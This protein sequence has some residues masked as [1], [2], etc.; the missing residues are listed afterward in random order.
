MVVPKT[1]SKC[2][3]ATIVKNSTIKKD[4]FYGQLS[5]VWLVVGGWCLVVIDGHGVLEVVGQS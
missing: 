3:R 1:S 5:I 2:D 4:R